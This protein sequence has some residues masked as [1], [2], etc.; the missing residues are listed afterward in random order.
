MEGGFYLGDRQVWLCH[1]DDESLPDCYSI[2]TRGRVWQEPIGR[3]SDGN[4]PLRD[5][6]RGWSYAGAPL[7]AP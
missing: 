1:P 2:V 6:L 4:E 7:P 3:V 5:L